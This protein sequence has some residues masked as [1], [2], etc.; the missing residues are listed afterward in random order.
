M[1]LSLDRLAAEPVECVLGDAELDRIADLTLRL[2]QARARR[3]GALLTQ[4][5]CRPYAERSETERD[6]M[7]SAV[8]HVVMALALLDIIQNPT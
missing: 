5:Q 1:S 7:R 2:H 3:S 6:G 8:R 4:L